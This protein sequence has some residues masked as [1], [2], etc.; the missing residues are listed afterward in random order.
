MNKN[1]KRLVASALFLALGYVLPF[2]T[3]QIKEIGDSLLPM[4]LAVML[5]G[6][7]CGPGYGFVVGAILPW[8]RSLTLGMPPLYPNSV[9]MALE[10]ATYGAVIGIM[11]SRFGKKSVHGTI[12]S[13]IIAIVSGRIVWGAAKAV[14][15]GLS[16]KAFTFAMFLA[17][18]IVDAI[19]GIIIQL[20][21]IPIIV[22]LIDKRAL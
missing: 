3:G 15:L 12:F 13:I 16:G 5:C 7:V 2:A 1:I 18:G 17:E 4:H 14:L 11:Y 21:F 10:L 19:P 9:W 22:K 6:V 20:I 8:F